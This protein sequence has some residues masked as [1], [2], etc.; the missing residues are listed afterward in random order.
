MHFVHSSQG[1]GVQIW[2]PETNIPAAGNLRRG[3]LGGVWNTLW[4]E[5]RSG[6]VALT[7]TGLE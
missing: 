2:K 5:A 4:V 3:A 1:G 6:W 7:S